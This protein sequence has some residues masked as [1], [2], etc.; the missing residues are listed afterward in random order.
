MATPTR[1]ILVNPEKPVVK[2]VE[3]GNIMR[4]ENIAQGVSTLF[5]ITSVT[6]ETAK[7][8]ID[9]KS[10]EDENIVKVFF[11]RISSTK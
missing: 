10:P 11:E 3:Y 9:F 6:G 8:K 4:V 5:V 2:F 1:I 7:I